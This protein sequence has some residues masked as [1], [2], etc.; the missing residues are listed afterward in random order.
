M[1]KKKKIL[2]DRREVTEKDF[3]NLRAWEK[4]IRGCKV[5]Y[6]RGQPRKAS[7]LAYSF[8]MA[9]YGT[10]GLYCFASDETIAA[11]LQCRR[12]D[13]GRYRKAVIELGWFRVVKR[14]KRATVLD[15][16]IPE[17]PLT[18]T[19]ETEAV[20]VPNAPVRSGKSPHTG[21]LPSNSPTGSYYQ[22]QETDDVWGPAPVRPEPIPDPVTTEPR[23][24][25]CTCT[26]ADGARGNPW[27]LIHSTE[28]LATAEGFGG[29]RLLYNATVD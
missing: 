7:L 5:P 19:I 9:S 15:I 11:D 10:N 6:V 3:D 22:D 23:A 24:T 20:A 4:Y 27:C 18:G 2:P 8:V 1:A 13:A 29:S 14:I 12:D 17:C 25:E 16:A 28:D 21:T 26:D